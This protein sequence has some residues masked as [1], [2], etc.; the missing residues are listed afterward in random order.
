MNFIENNNFQL[1][2]FN[3]AHINIHD[4]ENKYSRLP[5]LLAPCTILY[6]RP[7][8]HVTNIQT[9]KKYKYLSKG[10]SHEPMVGRLHFNGT[11]LYDL[12]NPNFGPPNLNTGQCV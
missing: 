8:P 2:I 10:K 6:F 11:S 5:L 1:Q 3:P 12:H 7:V 9:A 4:P